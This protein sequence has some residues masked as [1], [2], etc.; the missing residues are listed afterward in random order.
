[1]NLLIIG[2]KEKL[3]KITEILDERLCSFEK[4]K[5]HIDKKI[6]KIGDINFITYSIENGGE[7]KHKNIK[8]IF[9]YYVAE[10]ITDIVINIYQE[11]IIDRLIYDKYYYLSFEDK[12]IIK[13][14]VVDYLNRNE[15]VLQE[16]IMPQISKKTKILKTIMDFLDESDSL[17]IDGLVNFRLKFFTE[18]IEEALEKNIED[19]FVEKEYREFIRVLQYFVE[20]QESKVEL[21]NIIFKS[22]GTYQLFDKKMNLIDNDIFQ[23]L[24]E[25]ISENEMNYDDLLISSLITIAPKK[26]I[27]HIEKSIQDREIIKVI[28]NVFQ[29]KVSV[30]SGCRLCLK[31]KDSKVKIEKEK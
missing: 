25:E 10:A 21:V 17:I 20:L 16:G 9:N 14:R 7:V 27:I 11:K 29:N 2:F 12:K 13:S 24:A 22:D 19:F 5:I 23:E 30:C 3:E 4:E 8:N 15:Y 1:M 26:I 31:E 6:E 18:L 28:K